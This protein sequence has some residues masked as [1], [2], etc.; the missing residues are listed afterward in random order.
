MDITLNNTSFIRRIWATY[1]IPN[2]WLMD[3][4]TLGTYSYSF[5]RHQLWF[6][7][8]DIQKESA[9]APYYK[10]LSKLEELCALCEKNAQSFGYSS[11]VWFAEL[12]Q[13]I[14]ID[15][16]KS[17]TLDNLLSL[18]EDA[19]TKEKEAFQKELEEMYEEMDRTIALR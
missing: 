9:L 13:V 7:Y 8:T 16:S 11:S 15:L 6:D 12:P 14:D 10:V 2:K 4:G 18:V 5:L 1:N 19:I 17:Y 3:I